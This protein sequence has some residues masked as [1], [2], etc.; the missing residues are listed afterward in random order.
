MRLLLFNLVTDSDDPV[1]GFTTRWI[2]ALAKQVECIHVI[3]MRAGRVEPPDNVR[4]YSVGKERGYSEPRRVMEFY[5]LLFRIFAEYPIDA[6]FSHMNA[7]F[8]ILAAP[9]LKAKRIPIV[10]WYAHPKVT[11]I[12]RLAHHFSDQMVASVATAYP[13]KK[14]KLKVVGQ[15]I[16]TNLFSADTRLSRTNTPMILCVGRLSPVKDHPTLLKAAFL[17][18]Q[19]WGKPFRV[20]IVG[21]PATPRDESYVRL[22]HQR[23]KELGLESIIYFEPPVPMIS[24]PSWYRQCAVYV[25]MTPTGSGDKV[26]WES[27]SCERPCVL[28]NEGFTETLGKYADRLLF[29]Y[30]DPEDLANRL[31]GLLEVSEGDRDQMG[32]YLRQQ[33]VSMHSIDR[34]AG[35]LVELFH[36]VTQKVPRVLPT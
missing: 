19:S 27:M 2:R 7:I 9:M 22:L 29:R 35:T 15:G 11:W 34:L 1:L 12:L 32:L 20:V 18:R 5:R 6:C 30:N 28:A 36:E 26:A 21:G 23:V 14:D 24:L 31:L 8:T 13:Y 10:T 25:N 17:L 16:D 4:V 3:T 33:V